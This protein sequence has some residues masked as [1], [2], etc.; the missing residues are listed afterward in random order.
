[1]AEVKSAFEKAMERAAQ[2][3]VLTDEEKKG[4]KEI[5]QVKS[6]LSE[7]YKRDI[8]KD[9]LWKR[10]KGLGPSALREAQLNMLSSVR[11][12]SEPDDLKLR[13]DGILAIET[14]KGTKRVSNIENLLNSIEKLQR[15]YK[16]IKES[17]IKQLRDELERNPQMRVRP[18][19]TPDGRTVLQATVSVDEA[20]EA[21]VAEYLKEHE[22]RY[23]VMLERMK[24][25]L[26][27][28][29]G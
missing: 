16:Q 22:E 28:E 8:D 18:V 25:R 9:E 24:E 20:V 27:A 3:A 17:A 13:K 6:I 29:W 11:L 5:E 26:R 15:E 12:G 4:I 14:L 7:Y 21:H 10:M 19:R 1:M 2:I 23:E